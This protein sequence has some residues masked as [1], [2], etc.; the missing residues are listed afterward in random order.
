MRRSAVFAG[1]VS[2]IFAPVPVFANGGDI[3]GGFVAGMIG[4]AIVND[5]NRHRTYRSTTRRS[6]SYMST[7]QRD[8]NRETQTALNYFAYDVGAPDGVLGARSRSAVRAYQALLGDPVTG[9]L[10]P[11]ERTILIGAYYRGIAGGPAVT[12][13][14]MTDPNGLRGLLLQQRS[15]MAGYPGPASPYQPVTPYPYAAA[16]V[17]PAAPIA[18]ATSATV[19][20][21]APEA[22]PE[23]PP[24]PMPVASAMPSFAGGGQEQVS[25]ASHCNK[26]SLLT[27]SNGG[28]ET[29]STM[30][31]PEFAL[32][33]QFCLARTY[34][35]SAAEDMQAK[36]TGFTPQQIQ[37]QCLGFGPALKDYVSA[38]SLKP[39]AEV[40]TGVQSFAMDSGMAPAQLAST[41][42][43]CLGVG[44]RT[45]NMDV[46]V[47]S[48]LILTALGQNAYAELLGHHLS[49]G[50]GTSQRRD[51]ALAW[52]D[53]SLK[54]MAAGD[55]AVA[56]GMPG[57]AEL[58]Q[59]AAYMVM[60]GPAAPATPPV[61][62]AVGLPKF[63]VS[64]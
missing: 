11:Y 55:L 60:G 64:P 3:V 62:T 12:Q 33:E 42:K 44:Y 14:I 56:P 41:A 48:A 46:A 36:I 4:A 47:G 10:N 20:A 54:A 31:D 25:L 5:A 26:V 35:M 34:V 63:S 51:L 23:A 13:V 37:E 58:L 19:L 30:T 40:L 9:D 45:D 17:A 28:F 2:I 29:V 52:Y 57:R 18:P 15:E 7:E 50:F 24:E 43:I 49:L 16:P 21:A 61:P 6:T 38:L 53:T 22:E 27:N 39:E 8:S 59:K 1:C 32:S